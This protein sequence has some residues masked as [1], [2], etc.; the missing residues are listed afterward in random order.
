MCSLSPAVQ[1][2]VVI[3]PS[4]P[5]WPEVRHLLVLLL[6]WLGGRLDVSSQPSVRLQS[7]FDNRAAFKLYGAHS[8]FWLF[9]S[10][11]TSPWNVNAQNAL[12]HYPFTVSLAM[13][14]LPSVLHTGT[15]SDWMDAGDRFSWCGLGRTRLWC[16]VHWG[17]SRGAHLNLRGV[18]GLD[19]Q[20]RSK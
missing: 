3:H 2:P 1:Y 12:C 15:R 20:S 4:G 18:V 17:R 13:P 5:S 7:F 9:L 10:Y 8:S 6:L 19:H 16:P 14:V 11:R